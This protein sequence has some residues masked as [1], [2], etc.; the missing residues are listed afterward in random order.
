MA[1]PDGAGITKLSI[2]SASLPTLSFSGR[3]A[4]APSQ[5]GLKTR[6]DLPWP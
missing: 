5:A 1:L 4:L 6:P 2:L 3:A